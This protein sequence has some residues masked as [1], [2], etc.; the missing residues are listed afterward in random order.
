M[1]GARPQC[2]SRGGKTAATVR[3]Y[4]SANI[5]LQKGTSGAKPN[6]FCYWLFELLGAKAGDDFHDLFPGSGAVSR[7]WREWSW[8]NGAVA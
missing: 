6:D 1:G 7:A 3:D 8:H 4:V 2:G 5:T